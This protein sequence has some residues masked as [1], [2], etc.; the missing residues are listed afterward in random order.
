MEFFLEKREREDLELAEEI[1]ADGT[2]STVEN[3]SV[4]SGGQPLIKEDKETVYDTNAAAPEAPSHSGLVCVRV[5]TRKLS[6]TG[7]SHTYYYDYRSNAAKLAL[8][9]IEHAGAR[10]PCDGDVAEHG[11][12]E[13]GTCGYQGFFF[14]L[15]LHRQN[16]W[17]EIVR[18]YVT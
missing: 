2:E 1:E 10:N 9:C 6:K 18:A 4:V 3:P 13:H 12:G 7:Y 5:S 17:F 8:Y 14:G 16:I 15:W 11:H